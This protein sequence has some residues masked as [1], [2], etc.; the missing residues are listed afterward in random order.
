MNFN[1]E[2]LIAICEDLR[3]TIEVCHITMKQLGARRAKTALAHRHAYLR[4][5][6]KLL[7]A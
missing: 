3:Y 6:R 5:I 2:Q 1:V 4:D 7:E